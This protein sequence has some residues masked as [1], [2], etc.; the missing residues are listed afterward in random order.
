DVSC[1]SEGQP[2]MCANG[3]RRAVARLAIADLSSVD[4]AFTCQTSET[5]FASR[6]RAASDSWEVRLA[7]GAR[8]PR[9]TVRI[10]PPRS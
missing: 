3:G 4:G 9:L 10:M 8:R 5:E 1:M 7:R 6:K 2:D